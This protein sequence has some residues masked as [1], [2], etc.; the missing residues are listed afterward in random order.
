MGPPRDEARGQGWGAL[1][2]CGAV[3]GGHDAVLGQGFDA[4]GNAAASSGDA[5][6]P[7][8][9]PSGARI[10]SQAP[11]LPG[12]A[13]PQSCGE[14]EPAAGRARRDTTK[15]PRS[16]G[17]RAER[18]PGIARTPGLRPLVGRGRGHRRVPSL[19]GGNDVCALNSNAAPANSLG[20]YCTK[21]NGSDFPSRSDWVAERHARPGQ[22]GQVAGGLHPGD[23]RAL[24]AVDYALSPEILVGARVG[25]RDRTRIRARTPR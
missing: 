21:P 25:L 7:S 9:S 6:I 8:R 22:A 15:L 14:S 12:R 17:A 3:D 16:R 4:D 18:G 1:I 13:A 20:Y 19:P 2:P 11:R 24:I 10:A 23:L 5:S